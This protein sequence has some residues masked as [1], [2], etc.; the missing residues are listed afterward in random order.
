MKF[1]AWGVLL[2]LGLFGL[3]GCLHP[4]QTR[5]PTVGY[6]D[7][8]IERRAHERHDPF[9]DSIAGPDMMSRPRG[10]TEPRTE[11]R[12]AS[13]ERVRQ[14]AAPPSDQ[15]ALPYPSQVPALGSKYP[16]AIRP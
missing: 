6:G 16:N 8:R 15:S 5:M 2:L 12:R 4:Y 9:A 7:P 14:F 3:V 13:E 10:Y 1:E 11:P